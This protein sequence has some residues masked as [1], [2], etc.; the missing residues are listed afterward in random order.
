MF[1]S[2]V[3]PAVKSVNV[4]FLSSSVY[5][6]T[7]NTN[8]ICKHKCISALLRK[9]VLGLSL[10]Q[11]MEKVVMLKLSCDQEAQRNWTR[12]RLHWNWAV[13]LVNVNATCTWV[14][15][16]SGSKV[17]TCFDISFQNMSGRGTLVDT[18]GVRCPLCRIVSSA[19]KWD[20]VRWA[21]WHRVSIEPSLEPDRNL[22]GTKNNHTH[23]LLSKAVQCEPHFIFI[24]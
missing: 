6:Y 10:K 4:V 21:Q 24:F 22:R 12:N 18:E 16:G 13:I 8:L 1:Y 23:S 17:T 20:D 5:T 19:S 14:H 9:S 11:S 7:V 15:T 3:F 2:F